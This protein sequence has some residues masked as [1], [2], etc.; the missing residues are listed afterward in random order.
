MNRGP[1]PTVKRFAV[2]VAHTLAE[3]RGV[4]WKYRP[5]SAGVFELRMRASISE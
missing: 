3:L 4:F 2:Y 5:T 1:S